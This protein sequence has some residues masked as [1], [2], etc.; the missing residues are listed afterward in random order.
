MLLNN[1]I[2][3]SYNYCLVVRFWISYL[4][5]F[6]KFFLFVKIGCD[7]DGNINKLRKCLVDGKFRECC[8]FF[9]G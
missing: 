4:F 6:L 7:D 8:F 9:W 1:K 2:V 3:L 5:N